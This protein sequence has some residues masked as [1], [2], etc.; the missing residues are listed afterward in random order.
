[1]KFLLIVLVLVSAA[2][3]RV[4]RCGG[5]WARYEVREARQ[6]ARQEARGARREAQEYRLEARRYAAEARREAQSYRNELRQELRENLRRDR[7]DTTG[8]R[9]IF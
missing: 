4:E 1:M 5:R 6:W 7:P 3:A 2:F 8:M 9:R